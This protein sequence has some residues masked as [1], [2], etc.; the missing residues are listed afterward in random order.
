SISDDVND[1][2]CKACQKAGAATALLYSIQ[3]IRP[4]Q[5]S[6]YILSLLS[7]KHRLLAPIELA[8]RPFCSVIDTIEAR[9]PQSRFRLFAPS[10][11]SQEDLTVEKLLACLSEFSVSYSLRPEY[12]SHS[13]SWVLA[14]M[15]Q[16]NRLR[17]VVV[18]NTNQEIVGWYLY[19][20]NAGGI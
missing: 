3:W 17:K 18:R 15:S 1:A 12:D 19:Y 14:R 7:K 2:G 6:R 9:M 13:L 8:S 11:L 4:L 10:S 20:L 5:P 16:K